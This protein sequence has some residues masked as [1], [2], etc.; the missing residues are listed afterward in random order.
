MFPFFYVKPRKLSELGLI[1]SDGMIT[2]NMNINS[3]SQILVNNT[4]LIMIISSSSGNPVKASIGQYPFTEVG[5]EISTLID[6]TAQGEDFLKYGEVLSHNK[7]YKISVHK[8]IK[9]EGNLVRYEQQ[10]LIPKDISATN[11]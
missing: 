3:E 1:F 6:E 10:D 8:I 11:N 4:S 5:K 2:L 9:R 7:S